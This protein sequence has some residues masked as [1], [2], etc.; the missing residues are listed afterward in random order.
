M[1]WENVPGT[2]SSAEGEDFRIVL[3]ET[4][5]DRGTGLFSASTSEWEVAPCWGPLWE[6]D[7]LWL[8]AP[9][10]RNTGACPSAER[11]SS[12]WQILE[13]RPPPKYFLSQRACRGIL[14]RAEKRG[15]PLPSKLEWALQVQ[16]GLIQ[17]S[18]SISGTK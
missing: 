8:G 7:S 13:G 18:T 11:A 14:L 3:E 12:L 4:V 16:A 2:F 17:L 10:T 15:K 9:W 5:R 1:V 6:T